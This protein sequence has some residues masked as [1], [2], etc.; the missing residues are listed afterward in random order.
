ME[1]NGLTAGMATLQDETA[2]LA[3]INLVQPHVPWTREHLYWQFF[4][5]PVGPAKL[6]VIRD[7]EVI[8]SLYAAIR[9]ILEVDGQRFEGWMIQDVMTHPDFRGRGFLHYLASL[10]LADI[11]WSG[12]IGYTFPN[13]RSEGSFRRTGWA[14]LCEV[15]YREK[16]LGDGSRSAGGPRVELFDG[17]FGPCTA[18]VWDTAGVG[19]GVRPG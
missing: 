10:C 6:Y 14:E 3:L 16:A 17:P 15:P 19:V 2:L 11:K 8:V 18:D 4:D 12:G 1:L 5:S 13:D 7:G 9:Q